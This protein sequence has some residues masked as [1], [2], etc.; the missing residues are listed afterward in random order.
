MQRKSA[1]QDQSIFYLP[2][3][4]KVIFLLVMVISDTSEKGGPCGARQ[5]QEI[6]CF[7]LVSFVGK[8]RGNSLFQKRAERL[9][10]RAQEEKGHFSPPGNLHFAL[11]Q[12]LSLMRLWTEQRTHG[13]PAFSILEVQR[14][15]FCAVQ[16]EQAFVPAP[17]VYSV[18]SL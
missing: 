1:T 7:S 11:Q 2:G 6:L 9:K 10:R 15:L 18:A 14:R 16:P 3:V 12:L 8:G 17:I 13:K 5:S 4:M